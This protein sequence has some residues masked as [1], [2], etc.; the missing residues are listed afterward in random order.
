MASVLKRGL[1]IIVS[2]LLGMLLMAQPLRV[3]ADW[4]GLQLTSRPT[5]LPLP[6]EIP[7]P[8]LTPSPTP[9]P[10]DPP[11]PSTVT[12]IGVA[13]PAREGA[14][15]ELQVATAQTVWTLVQWQD[16]RGAWH[17]VDGWQGTPDEQGRV[18][19]WVGP[20]QLGLGPFRWVITDQPGGA[21][22]I[23][24]QPFNLPQR[25][26]QPIVVEVTRPP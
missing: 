10:I 18:R 17:T 23:V 25:A 16:G 5:L 20:T 11:P 26:R 8:T 19:W 9:L 1:L 14:T 3:Q 4:V 21:V 24:S 13:A 15:I 2:G 6:T 7:P 22:L 12:P